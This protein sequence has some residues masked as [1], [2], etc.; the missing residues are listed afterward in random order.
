MR[1]M[2]KKYGNT[3]EFFVCGMVAV[4]GYCGSDGQANDLEQTDNE[5]LYAEYE[6][7]ECGEI[8]VARRK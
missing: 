7:P 1:L 8:V 2:C 6:C 4:E 3:K 5:I